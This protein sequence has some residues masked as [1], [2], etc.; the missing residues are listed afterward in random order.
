[1]RRHPQMTQFSSAP[2]S[3]DETYL[4]LGVIKLIPAAGIPKHL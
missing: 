4:R 2:M 1:M 3:S